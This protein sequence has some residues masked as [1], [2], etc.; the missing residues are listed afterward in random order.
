MI[1]IVRP[2]DAT[3]TL[4]ILSNCGEKAF[5]I[6]KVVEKQLEDVVIR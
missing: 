3:S 5:E 1:L 4:Q 6:G 2:E